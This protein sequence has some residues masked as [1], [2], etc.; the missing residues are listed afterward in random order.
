MEV[1]AVGESH[2]GVRIYEGAVQ[3]SELE[4]IARRAAPRREARN[5]AEVGSDTT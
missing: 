3:P 5:W 4:K 1:G 2:V